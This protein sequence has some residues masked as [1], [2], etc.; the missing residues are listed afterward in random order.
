MNAGLRAEADRISTGHLRFMVG[1]LSAATLT[2]EG[3]FLRLLSIQQFY[4]FAFFVVSL[5]LLGFAASGTLLTITRPLSRQPVHRFLSRCGLGYVLSI[6]AAYT[7]VNVLPFDSY[8]IAWDYRQVFYFGFYFLALSIPF[9][10]SGLGIGS[11]LSAAGPRISEVYAANLVGAAA[12]A[13]GGLAALSLAGVPGGLML[14]ALI[15]GAPLWFSWKRWLAAAVLAVFG[16]G[17]AMLAAANAT[18]AGVLGLQISP[19]KGLSYARQYPGSRLVHQSWSA[20]SRLDLVADAGTR[21]LPGL[22]YASPAGPPP[23]SGL[24]VDGGYLQP[25]NLVQPELFEA[26]A[27]LPEALV[28]ELLPGAETLIVQPGAGLSVHQ[29]LAGGAGSV[30]L[31]ISDESMAEAVG[32]VS[33][34][35]PF[36]QPQVHQ[37]VENPRAFLGRT[38]ETFDLVMLP[39]NDGYQ[40]VASGAYSLSEN[41]LLTIEGLQAML[42]HLRPEGIL[43]ATRWLQTPPSED[44]RLVAS[45]LAA[46]EKNG[47]PASKSLIAFRGIQTLTVLARP[48]GWKPA[49]LQVVRDFTASRKF[50]LVWAPD[51]RPE[52]ANRYNIL[53]E[54][55][56]Y[57]A[58][59]TLVEARDSAM[60]YRQYPFDVAPRTDDRPYFFH[61]FKWR[62]TPEVLAAAGRLMLP[63]GGSGYFVLLAL[64]AFVVLVSAV[65]ILAPLRWA[66]RRPEPADG[67]IGLFQVLIYFGAIGLGFLFI[68]IPLIQRWIL[69][70]GQPIYAFS[71][72]VVVLL[73]ASGVGSA[74]VPRLPALQRWSLPVIGAGA[75][76]YAWLV[77]R[78]APGLLGLPI[79]LQ[80]IADSI[81]LAPLGFLLGFPFATGL[82]RLQARRPDLVPWAWAVN[83][84]ASVIAAV[85]AAI[86]ALNSGYTVVL[87]LGA[88]CYGAAWRVRMNT[89]SR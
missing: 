26:S 22:S 44:L 89:R 70:T 30:R 48:S 72:V 37:Q 65:L 6:G 39:L 83:G 29:A 78:L 58:V 20:A 81:L 4:H 75:L 5:A 59:R 42:R 21:T 73:T 14:S 71:F 85:V 31:L 33:P 11:G 63:F 54:A 25:V 34:F 27:Y 13:L 82:S 19:Y 66:R 88:V 56:L 7:L 12:G 16:A 84:S 10:F 69:F 3:T 47:W 76:L 41:H 55:E 60:F 32:T 36:D 86:L 68:E 40:P 28:F 24:S 1:S 74:L 18:G 62:Q 80:L 67:R 51:M 15:G 45:F 79:W 9:V 43:V 23:Q 77:E 46:L 53:P 61:F 8:S 38:A 2:L 35:D 50:D 17:F 64:L 52:E 87:W 57:E 49:T